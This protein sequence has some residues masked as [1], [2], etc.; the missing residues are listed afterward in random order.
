VKHRD[1]MP[2]EQIAGLNVPAGVPLVYQLTS[3]GVLGSA[4]KRAR[5]RDL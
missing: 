2:G 3:A 4:R 1:G 5:V